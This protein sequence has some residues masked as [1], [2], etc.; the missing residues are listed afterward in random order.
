VFRATTFSP[1]P[2]PSAATGRDTGICATTCDNI[3]RENDPKILRYNRQNLKTDTRASE[4]HQY[5][6]MY[7]NVMYLISFK[8]GEMAERCRNHRKR[9]PVALPQ[10][11]NNLPNFRQ[12]GRLAG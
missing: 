1:V 5:I 9:F 7:I 2:F 3:L 4:T 12:A 8:M 10:K 11:I 6:Y